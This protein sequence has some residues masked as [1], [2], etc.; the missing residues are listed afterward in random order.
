MALIV[1]P[2]ERSL[3]EENLIARY[4]KSG[5][6]KLLGGLYQNYM[7]LVYGVCLKY[8]KDEERSKDAVMQIFEELIAKLKN[9]EVKNFKSWLYVLS[10]NFCLMDLRK[11][12]KINKVEIDEEFM[13][14]EVLLHH[15]DENDKEKRLILMED[16]METLNEEQKL[17]VKLFYLQQKCYTEVAHETG[18]DLKKVKSYIQNGK[19]NLRLCIEKRSD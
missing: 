17:S 19:R 10:R 7:P 15:E 3:N 1:E 13:D 18:Y 11:T 2:A 5:D 16:C 4:K 12:S 9:H 6:L 14:S 8:F